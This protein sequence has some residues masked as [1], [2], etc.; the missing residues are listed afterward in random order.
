[1]LNQNFYSPRQGFTSE[2]NEICRILRVGEYLNIL[3]DNFYISSKY[4]EIFEFS[5]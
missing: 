1:M 4:K 3:T 2:I 5:I